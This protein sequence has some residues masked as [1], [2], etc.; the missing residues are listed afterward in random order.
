M[1]RRTLV[2]SG[3]AI[4]L[5][6]AAIAAQRVAILTPESGEQD[7]QFAERLAGSLSQLVRV[8]ESSLADDAYRAVPPEAPFNMTI[9]EGR[10]IGAAIGCDYFILVRSSTIR[11]S[12]FET[13]EY[14]EAYAAIFVVSS[15]TG[16]LVFFGLRKFDSPSPAASAAL[17]MDSAAAVSIQVFG[18]IDKV[19]K[20]ESSELDPP[21]METVPA[22]ESPAAKGLR[23]P[24]PYRRIKPENTPAAFLYDITA[25]VDIVAD[26]SEHG[27]IL[28]TRIE[29]W[30]G[31]GLD[32][33]VEKAV[34]SMDWRPAERDGKFLP[35]R[36]LLRYNF[37][38][39]EKE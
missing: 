12:S 36:V 9:S 10:R 26:I 24:I 11:R 2:K 32:E 18:A 4:L 16:R 27:K 33:S 3:V 30:A 8:S 28:R 29:H 14:Y 15:R 35:M 20:V 22:S 37:R 17:L 23:P 5:F 7:L 38:K 19:S 1:N 21:E 25:T 6:A 34:R 39:I 13:K 31:Y